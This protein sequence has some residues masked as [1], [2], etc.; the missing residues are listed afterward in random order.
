MFT[1]ATLSGLTLKW[2]PL[3]LQ[4]NVDESMSVRYP[5]SSDEMNYRRFFY[6]FVCAL[7]LPRN[8]HGAPHPYC[9]MIVPNFS[10]L[11]EDHKI[12]T[13]AW[14]GERHGALISLA[15]GSCKR[16]SQGEDGHFQITI[17]LCGSICR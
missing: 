7:G 8:I 17:D 1:Y 14:G 13:H 3:S 4:S 10:S 2:P 11:E 6:S 5:L 12:G 15:S 16:L 9:L